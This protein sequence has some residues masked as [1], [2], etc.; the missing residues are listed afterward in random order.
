V[1]G[2]LILQTFL[3]FK[4]HRRQFPQTLR[5]GP[6]RDH[7]DTSSLLRTFLSSSFSSTKASHFHA[8]RCSTVFRPHSVRKKKLNVMFSIYSIRL[9]SWRSYRLDLNRRFVQTIHPGECR[10]FGNRRRCWSR[11]YKLSFR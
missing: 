4:D 2:T 9:H 1:G 3:N 10:P 8:G 5:C 7:C 11:N 6:N